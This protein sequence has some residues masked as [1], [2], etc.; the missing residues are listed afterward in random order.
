M[1][2]HDAN[3][4]FRHKDRRLFLEMLRDMR[5]GKGLRQTDVARLAT[6]RRKNAVSEG[7]P[8]VST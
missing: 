4:G 6:F 3:L 7:R 2:R 1:E 5:V 8:M